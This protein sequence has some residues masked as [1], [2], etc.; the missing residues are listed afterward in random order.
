[1]RLTVLGRCGGYAGGG[2]ACT[3]YLVDAGA[4][5]ILVDVGYGAVARLL[6]YGPARSV[7]GIVLSHLHPDHVADL[8]ALQLALEY[9]SYPPTKWEGQVPT[10]APTR[11]REHLARFAP[12]ASEAARLVRF[13]DFIPIETGR[14][15]DFCGMTVQFAPARHA[16]EAYAMRLEHDN[17][18][19]VFTADTAPADA[20]ADL[21]T[22]AHVLLA[23][24]T[25]PDRLQDPAA[26]FAHLTG[27]TAGE[28]AARA[29]VGRLLLTHF[30]PGTDP[31]EQETAARR[32]FSG[33]V[34]AVVERGTYEI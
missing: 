9:E 18:V 13:F 33:P 23:E 25:F 3:G 4:A 28:M 2:G 31:R 34:E 29:R 24:A 19:L 22:G 20:V 5:R 1:M 8:P 30:F 16:V 32:V 10:L 11:A 14:R 6:E 12:V 15:F 7:S 17:R 26:S 21:A 27:T